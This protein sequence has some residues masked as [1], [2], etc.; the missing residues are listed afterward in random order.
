[1]VGEQLRGPGVRSS[2]FH[3]VLEGML[4][5]KRR[6]ACGSLLD[7]LSERVAGICFDEVPLLWWKAGSEGSEGGEAGGVVESEGGGEEI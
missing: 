1:M 3:G 2:F 5:R 7:G 4:V 6:G